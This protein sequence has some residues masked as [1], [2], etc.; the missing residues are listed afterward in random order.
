PRSLDVPGEDLR[1]IYYLRTLDESIGIRKAMQRA[2]RAVFV[3][4]GYL[5]MEVASGALERKLDVT[6]IEQ[7]DR[8]WSRFASRTLGG[9][10]QRYYEGEGARFIFNDSVSAFMGG[11]SV[12][13]VTTK[14]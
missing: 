1:E 5:N 7:T 3:G 10:M 11:G 6:I 13:A 4:A 14:G 8:P 12:S 2:K 9:F